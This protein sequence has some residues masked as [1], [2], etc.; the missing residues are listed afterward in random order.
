MIFKIPYNKHCRGGEFN[1]SLSF[2]ER[3]SKNGAAAPFLI[4]LMLSV[5]MVKD[6]SA[7]SKYDTR[8]FEAIG[9]YMYSIRFR[10]ERSLRLDPVVFS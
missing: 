5:L 4:F 2:S 3:V 6:K 7:V 8:S 9:S 10:S 1:R